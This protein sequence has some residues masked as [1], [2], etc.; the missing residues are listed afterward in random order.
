MHI[1][2]HFVNITEG[3]EGTILNIC[4]EHIAKMSESYLKP[5]IDKENAKNELR[6]HFE[7]NK[8]DKFE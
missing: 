2:H 4:N 8:Q 3:L 7:K 1:T 5:F 6:I